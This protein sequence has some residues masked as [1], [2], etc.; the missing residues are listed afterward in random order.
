MSGWGRNSAGWIRKTPAT[1][2]VD[3]ATPQ[4]V[5]EDIFVLLISKTFLAQEEIILAHRLVLPIV[6]QEQRANMRSM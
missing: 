3:T 1:K 6:N 4:W 2:A 5:M